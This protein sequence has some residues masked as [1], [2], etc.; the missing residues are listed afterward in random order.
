MKFLANEKFPL[1]S[2]L[3]LQNKGFDIQAIGVD[4][5]YRVVG[6]SYWSQGEFYYALVHLFK[7]QELYKRLGNHLG[8]GNA[9]MNIG[10]VYADHKDYGRALEHFLR[11]NQLF[12]KLGRDDRIGITYNKI[13][14]VYL[15]KGELDKAGKYLFDGL[16]IHTRNNFSFGILEACNRIGLKTRSLLRTR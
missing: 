11:A 3:Y 8:K 16:Y 5:H 6:V 12:E 10:L 7:S 4:N 1:K 14:S 13:G 15:E 2:V 9:T